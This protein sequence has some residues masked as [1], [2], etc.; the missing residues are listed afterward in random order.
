M[1]KL[2]AATL[3]ICSFFADFNSPS[4]LAKGFQ[5]SDRF[6]GV[7]HFRD[8]TLR[9]GTTIFAG[10][11]GLSGFFTTQSAIR[12]TDFDATALFEGLQVPP[13]QGLFRPGVTAFEVLEDTPAAFWITRANSQFGS[14]GWPQI[15]VPDFERVTKPTVTNILTNRVA[16]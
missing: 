13:R 2:L 9:K 1:V 5:G 14:G 10:E 3:V 7:D 16:P 15:F 8:I 11:P 12:R 6:P 4:K